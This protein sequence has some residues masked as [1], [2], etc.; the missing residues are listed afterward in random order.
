MT[1]DSAVVSYMTP[2][3]QASKENKW[4]TPKLKT[5]AYQGIL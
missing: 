5:F 2:K 3:T 4:T 1:V